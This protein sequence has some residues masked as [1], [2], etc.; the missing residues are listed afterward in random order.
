MS[1][2][3]SRLPG[4]TRPSIAA[5]AYGRAARRALRAW[6]PRRV[7]HAALSVQL[8][9][10]FFGSLGLG[11]RAPAMA[12]PAL[13]RLWLAGALLLALLGLAAGLLA[14]PGRDG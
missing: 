7:A 4:R 14:A 5:P 11:L 8:G 3:I 2:A 1:A 9:W 10:G 13:A 12:D 6:G